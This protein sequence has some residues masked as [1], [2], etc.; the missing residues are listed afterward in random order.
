MPEH[1]VS[2]DELRNRV[3]LELKTLESAALTQLQVDGRPV[4]G[5]AAILATSVTTRAKSRKAIHAPNPTFAVGRGQTV[6]FQR[7]AQALKY[8]RKKY[9]Q[10]LE[11]WRQ[12][13]RD[14]L[15]PKYTW[16]MSWLHRV[17]VE[18]G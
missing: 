5:R 15:F 12:G 1:H 11:Y 13:I 16:Q 8:F 9:Q 10:A 7:A 3:A 2:D 14:V 6:A 18:P 17:Q 4:L